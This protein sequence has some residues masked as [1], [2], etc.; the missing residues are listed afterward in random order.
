M[1]KTII[2]PAADDLWDSETEEFISLKEQTLVIEHSL[3][4]ISKWESKWKKPFLSISGEPKT[5]EE[6][7][8]YIRC[9]TINKVDPRVY[10]VIPFN[11]MK[12]ID[13]YIGDPMTATTFSDTRPKGRTREVITSE[14][15]YYQML[16]FGIPYEFEKWHLNRLITLIHV[17]AIKNGDQK[18][19]SKAEAAAYQRSL[20]DKRIGKHRRR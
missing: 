17:F 16:S 4:S 14:I 3:V 20:N 18:K 8:D 11:V 12:E 6:L 13:E 1:P 5:D 15:I 10:R 7:I 9:M 2:I 19:M